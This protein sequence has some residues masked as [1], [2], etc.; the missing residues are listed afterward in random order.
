VPDRV[1]SRGGSRVY[2]DD[3]GRGPAV[4]AIHGLGGGAWFFADVAG[5]L[6]SGSP[7][8]RTIAIDLPGTGRSESAGPPA[9]DRW[10][11]DL[12]DVISSLTIAPVVILG[13]SMG[14]IVA[15]Q[16][17]RAW[18]EH[19]RGL[20]FCGGLPTPRQEIRE[21]LTQR[22][23]A[24]ARDGLVGIGRQVAAVNVARATLERRPAVIDTFA[25]HF[26]AQDPATYIA[27]CRVLAEASAIDV[28]PAVRVPCLSI[29]GA[30]DQY[31]PPDLVSAF[32]RA[33]P[34]RREE[35]VMND[36]GHLPFLEDP[37]GFVDRVRPFLAAVC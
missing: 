37:D 33:I 16:A 30:E 6:A 28:V 11:A 19:I 25:S 36:C 26:E 29:T 5:R 7:A 21:R 34:G 17:W 2:V 27:C 4:L 35:V 13:H 24:V 10:V 12:G 22:A 8:F 3:R 1:L 31:A 20:I 14:T 23:A 15:L 9:I 32:M 18:P